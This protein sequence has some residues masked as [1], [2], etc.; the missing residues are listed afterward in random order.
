[1]QCRGCATARYIIVEIRKRAI[2]ARVHSIVSADVSQEVV[3]QLAAN[4]VAD[5]VRR[6]PGLLGE[7]TTP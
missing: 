7:K 5:L 2:L 1:M 3:K 6:M 4:S